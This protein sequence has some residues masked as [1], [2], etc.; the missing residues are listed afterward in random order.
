MSDVGQRKDMVGMSEL[1]REVGSLVGRL[2]FLGD[3]LNK[4]YKDRR[5]RTCALLREA[6]DEIERLEGALKRI[7]RGLYDVSAIGIALSALNKEQA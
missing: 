6:A 5:R 7:A 3:D 1:Q 4:G 2:R